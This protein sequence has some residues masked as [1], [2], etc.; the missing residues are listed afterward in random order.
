MGLTAN[1]S[2]PTS[3]RFGAG[4][5]SEIGGACMAAGI[6]RPL[7]VTDRGL[8]AMEI[9]SRTL[10]ILEGDGLGRARG[11][12]GLVAGAPVAAVAVEG[13]A[14]AQQRG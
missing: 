6:K 2:Y 13:E 12:V 9:T 3:V 11:M 1:W 7:L 10:D 8:A 5:I 14:R 4:R